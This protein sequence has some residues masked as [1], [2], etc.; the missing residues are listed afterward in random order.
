M[1]K[2]E[3]LK[4][5]VVVF[6]A[7]K[8]TEWN[9]K[10]CKAEVAGLDPN[11]GATLVN[12][13]DHSEYLLCVRGPSSPSWKRSEKANP[14]TKAEAQQRL[15]RYDGIMESLIRQIEVGVVCIEE[16]SGSRYVEDGASAETCAFS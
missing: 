9:K 6:S 13:E 12:P 4:G 14:P 11:V 7:Y 3:K 15:Q 8:L 16:I 2:Y 5:K 10:T 1:T